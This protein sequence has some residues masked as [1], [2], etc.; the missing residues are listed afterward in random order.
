ML[1][2]TVRSRAARGRVPGRARRPAAAPVWRQRRGGGKA[3]HRVAARKRAPRAQA[4]GRWLATRRHAIPRRSG[5]QARSVR[6]PRRPVPGVRRSALADGRGRDVRSRQRPALAAARTFGRRPFA[7]ID[8]VEAEALLV[9]SEEGDRS[10]RC[11]A[12]AAAAGRPAPSTGWGDRQPC[13]V[14]VRR[15]LL[16]SVRRSAGARRVVEP[17]DV[18]RV[19]DVSC[20]RTAGRCNVVGAVLLL[21]R[22]GIELLMRAPAACAR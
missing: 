7:E 1:Q 22:H 19:L 16:L 10:T 3:P 6:V 17:L 9:L 14:P 21:R 20:S 11:G 4:T 8:R 15:R 13:S 12:E 18:M 5:T 2:P